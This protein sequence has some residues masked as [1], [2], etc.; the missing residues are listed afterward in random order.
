[1][2]LLVRSSVLLEQRREVDE[3]L[4]RGRRGRRRTIEGRE[5]NNPQGMM[6]EMMSTNHQH[7][8]AM[9]GDWGW[10]LGLGVGVD[11]KGLLGVIMERAVVAE[12]G[13]GWTSTDLLMMRVSERT[14]FRAKTEMGFEMVILTSFSSIVSQKEVLP[15]DQHRGPRNRAGSVA[16]DTSG[17]EDQ[18]EAEVSILIIKQLEPLTDHV[19]E[20]PPLAQHPPHPEPA[21]H[22]APAPPGALNPPVAEDQPPAPAA[23]DPP[24]VEEQA[25]DA[26]PVDEEP[27]DGR[28]WPEIEDLSEPFKETTTSAGKRKRTSK[29]KGPPAKRMTTRGA[30]HAPV[31]YEAG[32]PSHPK[33][34]ESEGLGP[35]YPKGLRRLVNDPDQLLWRD[36][37]YF[38][39]NGGAR[40]E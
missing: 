39:L 14:P 27:P 37:P 11:Q 21:L 17:G 15:D 18:A 26:P 24:A 22:H 16:M 29:P 36:R 13:M 1:M 31:E 38:N 28:L 12:A 40:C 7:L 25:P 3:V 10:P 33:Y 32:D 30:V 20:Q 4:G 2:L 9:N 23:I 34:W 19:N 6:G 8:A 5:E 35:G